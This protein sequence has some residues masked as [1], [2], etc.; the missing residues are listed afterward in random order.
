[1]SALNLA[2]IAN[3]VFEDGSIKIKEGEDTVYITYTRGSTTYDSVLVDSTI[4]KLYTDS[5]LSNLSKTITIYTNS[6]GQKVFL[7]VVN[8]SV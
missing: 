7:S 5:A 8:P 4:T 3:E 6:S 1:M 2:N